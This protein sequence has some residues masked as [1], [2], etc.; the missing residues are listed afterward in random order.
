VTGGLRAEKTEARFTGNLL[1]L[2]EEG[3]TY[4]GMVLADDAVFVTPTAYSRNYSDVLPSL[5]LRY[6]AAPN[7]I[8]R[9]A[10]YG[11]VVRPRFS[12]A[13]PRYAVEQNEDDER[14]GEFGNPDLEPYHALNFDASAELYLANNGV[15]Q[16]GLFY[17][18]IKDFAVDLNCDA[19]D[20]NG[21]AFCLD[22][23]YNGIP[24]DEATVQINGDKAEVQGIELAYQQ[25]LGFL[26]APLDGMLI[27][28]NYTFTDSWG[29]LGDY[30]IPLPAASRNNYNAMLGYEK[31][32]LSLRLTGAYRSGYLDEFN[33]DLREDRWVKKHLQIDLSAKYRVSRQLQVFAEFVNLTDEPYVAYQKGTDTIVQDR[34]LQYEEYSWTAKAGLRLTFK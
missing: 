19:G 6:E 28:F 26:P 25:S 5:N 29:H 2:V 21:F 15:V 13:A 1:E 22:G 34:L 27:G 20:D 8:V 3:A 12:K 23:V 9:G 7:L 17:K 24:F 16:A 31:G 14:E 30:K 18:R 11:S 32:P 33:G 4:Q 10:M